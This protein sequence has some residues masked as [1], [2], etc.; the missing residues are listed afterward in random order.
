MNLTCKHRVGG[1]TPFSAGRDAHSAAYLC[2]G[3][4][5]SKK[6]KTQR[7]LVSQAELAGKDRMAS[8]VVVCVLVCRWMRARL[9]YTFPLR[10]F[11][12]LPGKGYGGAE[13]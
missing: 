12:T 4:S 1:G 2:R 9:S 8:F 10:S 11:W 13:L 6:G 3:V 7:D 5:S